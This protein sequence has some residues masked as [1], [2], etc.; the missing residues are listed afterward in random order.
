ML[1]L[2]RNTQQWLA[3]IAVLLQVGKQ[4]VPEGATVGG[5]SVSTVFDGATAI[6]A[7][8]MGWVAQTST[9]PVT[10]PRLP[11]GTVV[12]TTDANGNKTGTTTV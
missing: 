5:V 7:A 12:T 4:F 9:T 2:G 1:F 3:L 10:D 11:N 8:I 6:V